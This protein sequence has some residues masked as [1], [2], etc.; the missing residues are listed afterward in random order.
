MSN[1]N[2]HNHEDYGNDDDYEDF[3]EMI[4]KKKFGILIMINL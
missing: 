3:E 1:K 2:L 4:I